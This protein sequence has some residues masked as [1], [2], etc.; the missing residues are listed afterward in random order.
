[1]VAL[2][3]VAIADLGINHQCWQVLQRWYFT[4]QSSFEST[5]V[6]IACKYLSSSQE[7]LKQGESFEKTW[8]VSAALPWWANNPASL[9]WSGTS[10]PGTAN[11]RVLTTICVAHL[12]GWYLAP[13]VSTIH[14][15]MTLRWCQHPV[16][17]QR[18][19]RCFNHIGRRTL[20]MNV[21]QSHHSD[22]CLLSTK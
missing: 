21:M 12:M 18:L 1:M 7:A 6:M 8:S 11:T 22:C 19:A 16:C 15:M 10:Q 14:T 9:Q 4:S 3:E 20:I 5:L 13:E 17:W 2:E